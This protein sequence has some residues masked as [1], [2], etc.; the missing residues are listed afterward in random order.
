MNW[1]GKKQFKTMVSVL[2]AASTC[3]IDDLPIVNQIVSGARVLH[4]TLQMKKNAPSA[5]WT[6]A[7]FSEDFIKKEFKS[8]PAKVVR[9]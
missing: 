5:I 3:L 1:N 7:T 6:L 2:V 9:P 8:A 4:R